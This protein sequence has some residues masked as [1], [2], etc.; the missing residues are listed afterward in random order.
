MA[1]KRKALLD[2]LA[3]KYQQESN[4]HREQI[5]TMT[6]EHESQVEQLSK[7]I[8]ELTVSMSVAYTLEYVSL[9]YTVA[10]QWCKQNLLRR[11]LLCSYQ[12]QVLDFS[13]EKISVQADSIYCFFFFNTWLS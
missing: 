7:Q 2:E 5:K 6:R 11:E 8:D 12:D 9:I 13:K 1:E 4:E 10:F 3:I